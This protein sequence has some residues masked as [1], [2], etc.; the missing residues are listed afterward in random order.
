MKYYITRKAK[1]FTAETVDETKSKKEADYL[2]KEYQISDSAANYYIS[3]NPCTN[4]N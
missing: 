4:W 2:R 3:N 1:G